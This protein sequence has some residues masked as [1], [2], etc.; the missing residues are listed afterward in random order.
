LAE[1]WAAGTAEEPQAVAVVAQPEG[2][3]EGEAEEKRTAE[4]PP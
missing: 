4:L 1:P 3:A 2:E